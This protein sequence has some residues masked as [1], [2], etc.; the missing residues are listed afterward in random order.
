[1]VRDFKSGRDLAYPRLTDG[2]EVSLPNRGPEVG[3]DLAKPRLTDWHK[4]RLPNFGPEVA[5]DL[6]GTR[7]WAA[8]WQRTMIRLYCVLWVLGSMI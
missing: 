8:I 4:V 2:H 3:R 1:M 5:R 7:K 6:A